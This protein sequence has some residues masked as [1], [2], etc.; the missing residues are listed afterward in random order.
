MK[1]KHCASTKF[2]KSADNLCS[3]DVWGQPGRKVWDVCCS[4]CSPYRTAGND[5][6]EEEPAI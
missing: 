1:T 4:Q 2:L 5:G 6:D 3:R